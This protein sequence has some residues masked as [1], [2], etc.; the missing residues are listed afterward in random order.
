MSHTKEKWEAVKG[1]GC[2]HLFVDS[3]KANTN[4]DLGGIFNEDRAKQI[5]HEHNNFDDMEKGCE[6]WRKQCLEA[7]EERDRL[8]EIIRN[9]TNALEAIKHAEEQDK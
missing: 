9:Y 7:C 2:F 5:I 4:N 3:K 8:S 6:N 1:D